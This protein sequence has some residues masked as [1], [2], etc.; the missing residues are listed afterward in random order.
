ME[1]RTNRHLWN[2]RRKKLKEECDEI[3]TIIINIIYTIKK[4]G[5]HLSEYVRLQTGL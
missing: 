5:M 1:R 3:S 4:T 2:N